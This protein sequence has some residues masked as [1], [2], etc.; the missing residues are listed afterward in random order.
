MIKLS[1]QLLSV[2]STDKN[3]R[4]KQRLAQAYRFIKKDYENLEEEFEKQ[5]VQYGPDT[6]VGDLI[7]MAKEE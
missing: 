1:S 6:T 3:F 2:L 7:D 4:R 5:L